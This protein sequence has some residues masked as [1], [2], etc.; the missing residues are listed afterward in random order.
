MKATAANLVM[1]VFMRADRAR[2]GEE[3]LSLSGVRRRAF[4]GYALSP[5]DVH[6]GVTDLCA[7]GILERHPTKAAYRVTMT[8]INHFARSGPGDA[9]R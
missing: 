5:S 1:N 8:G 6:I 7:A 3:Y 4:E 9:D 2:W